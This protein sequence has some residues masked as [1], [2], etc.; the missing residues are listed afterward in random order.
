M[1]VKFLIDY[2]G[3][4]LRKLINRRALIVPLFIGHLLSIFG[5]FCVSGPQV[6]NVLNSF[7]KKRKAASHFQLFLLLA[8][9]LVTQIL[10]CFYSGHMAVKELHVQIPLSGP[11]C[12]LL[13]TSEPLSL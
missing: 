10:I 4:V 9:G 2:H 13:V 6:I 8:R 5:L 7:T 11:P 1:L 12:N 3:T